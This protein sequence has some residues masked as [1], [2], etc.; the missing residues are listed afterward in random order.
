[1]LN[2][3]TNE[4]CR[5]PVIPM[6]CIPVRISHLGESCPGNREPARTQSAFFW[7]PSS[8][9]GLLV[10]QPEACKLALLTLIS[11]C[12]SEEEKAIVEGQRK[13]NIGL[14]LETHTTDSTP[15][16]EEVTTLLTP[17][18]RPT[19]HIAAGIEEAR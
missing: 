6:R 11:I 2:Q 14:P 7:A 16:G 19:L 1:M 4:S 13:G 12:P 8:T 10:S 17:E 15:R 18:H 3:P 9:L 5:N